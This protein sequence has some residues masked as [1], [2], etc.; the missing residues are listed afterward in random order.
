MR[1]KERSASSMQKRL[2][3]LSSLVM[4]AALIICLLGCASKRLIFYPI[5][6]T[7]IYFKDNGD[8]CFSEMYFN[9]VLDAEIKK[10]K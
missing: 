2:L 5:Q 9:R 8:I 7:D 4:S 6:D 1:R 3:R 10:V